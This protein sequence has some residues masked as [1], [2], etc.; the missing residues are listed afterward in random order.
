MPTKYNCQ[1]SFGNRFKILKSILYLIIP[2]KKI[3]SKPKTNSF[4]W[5]PFQ[6]QS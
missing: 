5:K 4:I 2:T 3:I 1:I 6:D